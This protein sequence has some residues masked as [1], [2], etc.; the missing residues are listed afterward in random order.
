MAEEAVKEEAAARSGSDSS[1]AERP[2]SPPQRSS[3][4]QRQ[5]RT[6]GRSHQGGARPRFNRRPM[7]F[8]G[9]RRKVCSFCVDKVKVIDWKNVDGF[10]RFVGEGGSIRARRKTG[11]C[12]KH[13]RR[14]AVAIKRARH[15]ALL[16][17]TNE[18]IRLSHKN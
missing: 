4:P 10:R 16:P 13:Q 9:R 12:A 8:R 14:L 1:R 17:F 3:S 15:L 18:H 11:T 6:G 2:S 5:Q 7:H